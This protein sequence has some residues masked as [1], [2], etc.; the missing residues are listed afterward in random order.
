MKTTKLSCKPSN[1]KLFRD[2][3][4]KRGYDLI[5]ITGLCELKMGRSG[6]ANNLNEPNEEI[7]HIQVHYRDECIANNDGIDFYPLDD[8]KYVIYIEKSSAKHDSNFI[9]FRRINARPKKN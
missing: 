5:D 9:I 2:K 7:Y 4:L 3:W 8:K 1:I 6:S